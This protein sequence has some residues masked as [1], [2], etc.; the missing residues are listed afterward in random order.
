M[1]AALKSMAEFSSLPDTVL[2]QLSR[3]DTLA[4]LSDIYGGNRL[5]ACRLV[6]DDVALARPV[7]DN[8]DTLG[9]IPM[10]VLIDRTV[11]GIRKWAF[12]SL[13]GA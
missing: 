12:G 5:A 2:N 11:Y 1:H 3:D 9:A 4:D 8:H 6:G 7:G 13:S 10:A